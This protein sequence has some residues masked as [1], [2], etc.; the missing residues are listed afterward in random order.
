[1]NDLLTVSI[2]NFLRPT[3][4]FAAIWCF[5]SY[6]CWLYDGFDMWGCL[7]LL[8]EL[9]NNVYFICR[10][11]G[12]NFRLF[13]TIRFLK[14][15][16]DVSFY[17]CWLEQVL[18]YC[19]VYL[20]RYEL[21][22]CV[23]KG[24]YTYYMCIERERLCCHKNY[25][26]LWG[27]L[28]T[29]CSLLFHNSIGVWVHIQD[30]FVSDVKGRSSR[31]PDIEMGY[32]VPRSNSDLGMESFN[33]QVCPQIHT[34]ISSGANSSWPTPVCSYLLFSVWSYS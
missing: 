24:S 29:L 31:E 33:K 13:S 2:F 3:K 34:R 28:Y 8:A 26:L 5:C 7:L 23:F 17:Y 27:N 19:T 18:M 4:I 20:C 14:Y 15:A 16:E 25:T 21:S 11:Y 10:F 32:R 22:L 9:I 12:S 6:S 30:S 1:M